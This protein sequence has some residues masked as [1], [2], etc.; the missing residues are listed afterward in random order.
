MMVA[1][2]TGE[3]MENRVAGVAISTKLYA[4]FALVVLVT[5]VL[6]VFAIT[7]VNGIGQ[8]LAN[9]DSLRSS[10]LEPLVELR[11]ALDQTGIAARNAFIF[12]DN[13]DAMRELDLVDKQ[14]AIYQPALAKLDVSLQGNA[15]FQKLREEMA[16]MTRELERPRK[17]RTA[18]QMEAYGAFLVNECSPLRRKI[19]ADIEVLL[20]QLQADSARASVAAGETA[21]SARWMIGG[22]SVLCVVLAAAIGVALTRS[23][24]RELGGEPA[25][26]SS[27]AHAIARG[28]LQH[29]VDTRR[30]NPRSLLAAMSTM[31]DSLSGIV[32]K[33]R[34][35][36]E[37]IASA[38][39]EIATGNVD[40]SQ[41]TE[42]QAA[43]LAQVAGA[44][45]E[46]IES[47][48]RNADYAAEASRLARDASEVSRQGG[49]AVAGVVD[50]MNLIH[51]SSRKIVEII[52]VIDGIAFQTNILAL[53]AAVEAARAGEQ[54]RGFAV[55]ASEVRN[56][57]HRSAA[58]AKEIK[59]LI[60]DS[61]SKV[62]AGTELVGRAG[63]T[64]RTV[65]D[66]VHKVNDIIGEISSATRA[67]SEEIERVDGAIAQ[68]DE[69]TLQNAALVEE[70][71]AAAQSLRT[72]AGQLAS[73]V[74]TFQ[75][76]Q[77]APARRSAGR[78][79]VKV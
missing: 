71:S 43:E 76:E 34:S 69:M 38:S 60:E 36:T 14:I 33:V 39:A 5:L 25:Y 19:V 18:G 45:K 16:A 58:A 28:E 74:N 3:K 2:I 52:S 24:L 68:L 17:Y 78:A 54:G 1:T 63:Q 44:M 59:A 4:A 79:L 46:L 75:L 31:R 40:L 6:A 61:V 47:V 64:M 27:V 23:L 50:T 53:N 62:G 65:V 7:R 49:D 73:L 20:K 9:A 72:Q 29:S 37:A 11:E 48:R 26:A 12:S 67:Q 57:A 8:S 21:S 41:R 22:L 42:S 32:G 55:V 77:A 66:G 10:R 35:G 13:A 30:A 56:L 70:A 15:Q 51:D